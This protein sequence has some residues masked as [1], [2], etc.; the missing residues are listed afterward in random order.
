[1]SATKEALIRHVAP[2]YRWREDFPILKQ[3]VYGKPLVYL[4]N[5]ATSQKPASVIETERRYYEECNANVHRG[6]HALS[7]KATDAYE[8]A[9]QKVARFL[10][11]RSA[12]EIVFVRGCTEGVNLVAQSYGRTVLKPGDEVLITAMEH[13]SNIVP[14]QMVCQQTGAVLRVAPINDAGEMVFE[15]FERLVSERTRI[16]AAVHVSNALG[17]INP[18]ERIVERAHAVGAKVLLD[19]AQAV[20]HVPVDVQALDCDFYAFSGH[21]IY[22]PTGIGALYGKEALLAAMPPY[23]GGGDMIKV[24]TFDK[25]LY[26]DLPYKFEAGTPH[27]AG[28]VGLGAALDYVMGIGMEAIAAHEHALLQYATEAVAGIKGLRLVGTARH[29]AGILS[30]VMDGVHPHDIGT[31]LDHQGVA[32]RAGHHCAMPVMDRYGVAATAR[33][34]FALYNT[35]E[36]VDALVAGLH[37]VREV[38]G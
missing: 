17:T 16:V 4:D 14:W 10:N 31:I 1:M 5:A 32:I 19:G 34:S 35:R 23:Q 37:K 36:D 6:V 13:H 15:E 12:R 24:V 18:V 25:T 28:A 9:R 38:F 2:A 33:A 30:F 3:Q 29:K 22:G 20:P 11:A 26:N 8:G 21:K 27:I 7:Q